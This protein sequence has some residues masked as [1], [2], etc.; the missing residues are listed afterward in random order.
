MKNSLEDLPL[1]KTA[2]I[3][4]NKV[5]NRAGNL[6]VDMIV[7]HLT[8]LAIEG[9]EGS[10]SSQELTVLSRKIPWRSS[11]IN[12]IRLLIVSP[13]VLLFLRLALIVRVTVRSWK[14]NLQ[15]TIH[16]GQ[17]QNAGIRPTKVHYMLTLS[18]M[19]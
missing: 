3:S 19:Y 2:D 8:K 7:L 1:K 15:L 14:E 11:R 18:A 16:K 10:S 12:L 13:F 5:N 9:E 17:S 4:T 6:Q